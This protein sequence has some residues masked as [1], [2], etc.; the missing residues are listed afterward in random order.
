[1][2]FHESFLGN[3]LL[4][5]M[6]FRL[7]LSRLWPKSFASQNYRSYLV[8]DLFIECHKHGDKLCHAGND[9]L[10][11]SNGPF[12]W[13]WV[14]IVSAVVHFSVKLNYFI[15]ELIWLILDGMLW[16]SEKFWFEAF[17]FDVKAIPMIGGDPT[18][19]F[20]FNQVFYFVPQRQL[21]VCFISN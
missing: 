14:E 10:V 1:M 4:V 21:S 2:V 8:F 20:C 17:E 5:L 11:I 12:K 6:K 18:N 16:N 7:I 15:Q 9:A 3:K 13:R 19:N